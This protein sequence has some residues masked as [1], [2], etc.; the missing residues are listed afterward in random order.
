MLM[1]ILEFLLVL[2]SQLID[3]SSSFL[4]AETPKGKSG[5]IELSTEL[6][7]GKVTYMVLKINKI[8]YG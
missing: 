8:L 4:K 7:C 1:L 3:I 6:T 5:Y 2:K